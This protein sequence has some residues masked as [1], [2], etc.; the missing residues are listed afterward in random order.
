[1]TISRLYLMTSLCVYSVESRKDK[2][3]TGVST[4][5]TSSIQVPTVLQGSSLWNLC[6]I[7]L[8]TQLVKSVK[9]YSQILSGLLVTAA[10]Y[11]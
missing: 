7:I 2:Q 10:A 5:L 9:I 11:L 6:R 8:K 3:E 4:L 1:M